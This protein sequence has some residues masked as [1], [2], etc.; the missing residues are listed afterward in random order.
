M[1][2]AAVIWYRCFIMLSS[3]HTSIIPLKTM[4]WVLNDLHTSILA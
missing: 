3:I 1:L 4:Q 2:A